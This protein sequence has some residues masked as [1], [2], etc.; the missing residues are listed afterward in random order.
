MENELDQNS[1]SVD[2]LYNVEANYKQALK[3]KPARIIYR[4][5]NTEVV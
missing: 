5:S 3:Q 1:N 2:Y 4:L